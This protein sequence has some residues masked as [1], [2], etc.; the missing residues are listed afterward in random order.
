MRMPALS[1]E[2]HKRVPMLQGAERVDGYKC[3][4]LIIPILILGGQALGSGNF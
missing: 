1:S 3:G 4:S 2:E